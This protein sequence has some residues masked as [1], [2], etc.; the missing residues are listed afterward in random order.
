MWRRTIPFT[1]PSSNEVKPGPRMFL[2]PCAKDDLFIGFAIVPGTG[3]SSGGINEESHNFCSSC[4]ASASD[5]KPRMTE[6]SSE[7]Q[8]IAAALNLSL[9]SKIDE[10]GGKVVAIDAKV[11]VLEGRVVEHEVKIEDH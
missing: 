3:T 2:N 11:E 9:G 4:G 10:V 6:K 7:G 8:A 5:K 1:P